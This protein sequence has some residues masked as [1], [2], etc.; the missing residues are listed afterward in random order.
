MH[1]QVCFNAVPVGDHYHCEIEVWNVD[2][3]QAH[4]LVWDLEYD[5]GIGSDV[6]QQN[7]MHQ[8]WALGRQMVA[9]IAADR[10]IGLD[11]SV[12]PA[13]TDSQGPRAVHPN[14]GFVS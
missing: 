5:S 3:D 6:E 12:R 11:R 9:K 14:S 10:R 1:L 4:W 7:A 2:E 8:A 13:E